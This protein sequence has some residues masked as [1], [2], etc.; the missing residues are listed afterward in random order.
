MHSSRATFASCLAGVASLFLVQ[1]AWANI[2]PRFWGDAT[3]EPWGLKDVAITQERLTIDLRPLAGA[4]PAQ[5]EVIY[6]LNNAGASRHLDLLFVSGEVGVRDF[7]AHLGGQPL[8]TR[9]LPADEASRLWK[10]APSSWRP[11]QEAPGIELEKTF[12]LVSTWST[13]PELVAFSLDLPPGPSTLHVRYKARACGAGERPTVTWQF[14]Y[15]LAPAREWGTFGRLDVVV[16][17]PDGWEARSTPALRRERDTLRGSFNEVPADALLLATGAPVPVGYYW[18]T[19]LALALWGGVLVGGPLMCWWAG[20]RLGRARACAGA[21]GG[22][23]KGQAARCGLLLGFFPALLWGALIYASVPVSMAIIKAPLHGQERPSAEEPFFAGPCL[24]YFIIP[25][26]VL[27][28]VT[29]TL[30]SAGRATRRHSTD[31]PTAA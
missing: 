7:E 16:H 31:P 14:P 22:E 4:N 28:G 21:P 29:L 26:A 15:V 1:V 17:V 13:P 19:G 30:G 2:A 20:R 8:P 5:V 6:D 12:Y 10:K 23:A 27:F 18:A 24:N 25:A 9:P 11:P 3:S